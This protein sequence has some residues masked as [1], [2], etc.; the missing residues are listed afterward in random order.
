MPNK[1]LLTSG[2]HRKPCMILVPALASVVC[3]KGG[4]PCVSPEPAGFPRE[5]RAA[6]PHACARSCVGSAQCD[7]CTSGCAMDVSSCLFFHFVSFDFS[8][9]TRWFKRFTNPGLFKTRAVPTAQVLSLAHPPPREVG[10][11]VA[12][13][14]LEQGGAPT[15]PAQ[16]CCGPLSPRHGVG[17]LGR[18]R[19]N[20]HSPSKG[21]KLQTV[22][23]SQSWRLEVPDPGASKVL[24]GPFL[25]ERR[26]GSL[27]SL[28][29]VRTPPRWMRD[30]PLGPRWT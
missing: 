28:L 24:T 11:P 13:S 20:A 30:P 5:P 6:S 1:H 7:A 2:W 14:S 18:R 27:R 29:S 3:I 15:L 21:L 10:A 8:V 26:E 9:E 23:L 4:S 22:I 12:E 19:P 25:C 16:W 17:L